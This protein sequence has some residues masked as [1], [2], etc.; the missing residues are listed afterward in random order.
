M[1]DGVEV[2][3]FQIF[4]NTTWYDFVW[5]IETMHRSGLDKKFTRGPREHFG[6]LV[7]NWLLTT[8]GQARYFY[9]THHANGECVQ[10]DLK[11]PISNFPKR[12]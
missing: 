9:P 7:D 8:P 1:L 3:F 12:S 2:H 11:A 10:G 5:L 4:V 6:L